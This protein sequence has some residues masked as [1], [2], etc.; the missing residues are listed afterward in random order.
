MVSSF[1]FLRFPTSDFVSNLASSVVTFAGQNLIHSGQKKR[2]QIEKSFL[3]ALSRVVD[4]YLADGSRSEESLTESLC[5][6][7]QKWG[8]LGLAR[9]PS[10]L[11]AGE[12]T[13]SECIATLK[14]QVVSA[15]AAR[16][17]LEAL[18]S[19]GFSFKD[20]VEVANGHPWVKAT[21]PRTSTFKR[22][23]VIDLEAKLGEH[24]RTIRTYATSDSVVHLIGLHP[25]DFGVWPTTLGESTFRDA[26]SSLL[27]HIVNHSLGEHCKPFLRPPKDG[28]PGRW[29]IVL[30]PESLLGYGWLC[31]AEMLATD[32]EIAFCEY[33][34]CRRSFPIAGKAKGKGKRFCNDN[35]RSNARYSRRRK[36]V[37]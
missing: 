37:S 19:D 6:M 10:D 8:P 9:G 1:T 13:V 4:G 16:V 14:E 7:A 32:A 29:G 24:R 2:I 31:L 28:Q 35:C 17:L 11:T 22:G 23:I 26:I 3:F 21:L 30:H 34:G 20:K 18:K 33:A 25:Q 36:V 5:A 27:Q 12:G 15:F